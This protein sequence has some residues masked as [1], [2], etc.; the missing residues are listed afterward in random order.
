MAQWDICLENIS[1]IIT[2]KEPSEDFSLC[3]LIE[4]V[5]VLI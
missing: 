1:I 2:I 4:L 3:I 5:N